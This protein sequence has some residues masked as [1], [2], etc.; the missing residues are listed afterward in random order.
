MAR[1]KILH[2]TKDQECLDT[3]MSRIDYKHDAFTRFIRISAVILELNHVFDVNQRKFALL[4]YCSVLSYFKCD[5]N[6]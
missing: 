1:M 2:A 4:K 6:K 3:I 5:N